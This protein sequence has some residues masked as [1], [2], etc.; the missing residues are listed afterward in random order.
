MSNA[1]RPVKADA[2]RKN[3]IFRMNDE[4]RKRLERVSGDMRMNRSDT[5]RKLMEDYEKNMKG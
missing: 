2:K 1:G 3:F 4:D 5:I